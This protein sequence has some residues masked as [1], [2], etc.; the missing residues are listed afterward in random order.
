MRSL[1]PFFAVAFIGRAYTVRTRAYIIRSIR[2]L[3]A[4]SVSDVYP[5]LRS[6]P[7]WPDRAK[8]PCRISRFPRASRAMCAMRARARVHAVYRSWRIG[9]ET[10]LF[11]TCIFAPRE[12]DFEIWDRSRRERR[13]GE[14][15]LFFR[16]ESPIVPHVN[17]RFI[18]R[19]KPRGCFL[20]SRRKV[21]TSGER[22]VPGRSN[23]AASGKQEAVAAAAVRCIRNIVA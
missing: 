10:F 1:S 5:T 11:T 4:V 3:M 22:R 17:R 15:M 2:Y 19:T 7:P 20:A 18:G 14:D 21:R 12:I 16:S 6:S 8:F 9:R 13:R 23:E